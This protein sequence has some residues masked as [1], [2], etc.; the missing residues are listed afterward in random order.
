M[1]IGL[2]LY[3][4]KM[5]GLSTVWFIEV[6]TSTYNQFNAR[7]GYDEKWDEQPSVHKF[8]EAYDETIERNN[9]WNDFET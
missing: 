6:L 7:Q 1:F 3:F 5:Q 4:Y 8:T 2:K 9:H